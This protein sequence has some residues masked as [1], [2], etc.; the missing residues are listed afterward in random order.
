MNPAGDETVAG[1]VV[2]VATDIRYGEATDVGETDAGTYDIT[3]NQTGSDTVAVESS[4]VVVDAG[5]SYTFVVIGSGF[6]LW[7]ARRDPPPFPGQQQMQRARIPICS[8]RS[9]TM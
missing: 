8:T 1:D 2:P 7:L 3:A 4:G 6:Y 9:S 5:Q